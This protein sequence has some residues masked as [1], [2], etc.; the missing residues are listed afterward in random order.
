MLPVF[1]MFNNVTIWFLYRKLYNIG[2]ILPKI[3]HLSMEQGNFF[4]F[5]LT[6]KITWLNHTWNTTYKSSEILSVQFNIPVQDENIYIHGT[7]DKILPIWAVCALSG[8]F[9]NSPKFQ[10]ICA[11][12]QQMQ[13]LGVWL[14]FSEDGIF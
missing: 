12:L 5:S 8:I 4:S 10:W 2:R 6:K 14:N 9:W 1:P 3:N 13:L 7:N 11:V